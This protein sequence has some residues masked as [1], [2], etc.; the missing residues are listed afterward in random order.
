[1]HFG[2]QLEETERYCWFQQDGAPCH[3]SAS[4]MECLKDFFGDRII[5]KDLWPPRSPDLTS[6]DF[7]LWGY[8]KDRVYKNTPTTLN[9]LKRNIEYEISL[10]GRETLIKVSKNMIKRVKMCKEQNGNHFQHLL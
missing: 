4:T 8:L 1:M 9:Q 2:S 6:L 5:S 3:T 7:F 10:I